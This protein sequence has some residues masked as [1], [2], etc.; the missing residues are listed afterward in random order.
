MIFG[1][2]VV[3]KL[4]ENLKPFGNKVLLVYGGGSIKKSG[5][6]D[7]VKELLKDFEVYELGGVAPNPKYT[8]VLE[9][10]KI[11]KEK[12]IEVI[13]PVGG[14]SVVDC[15]K[16][17]GVGAVYDGEAW[18]L[19]SMKV[20]TKATLPVVDVI[21]MA[22]T[23]SEY[24]FSAVITNEATGEKISYMSPVIYPKV[25]F[26]DPQ[27]TFTVPTK[28]TVAGVADAMNH[29]LEQYFSADTSILTDGMCIAALRSL[30]ENVKIVLEKPDDYQARA[31]IFVDATLGC[32]LIFAIGNALTGWPMHALEHALSAF[33]DITHGEGLAILTPHWMK[34]ILDDRTCE[35]FVKLGTDLF[36]MD[37]SM[38]KMEMANKVIDEFASFFK[39]LGLPM[40]LKEVGI[41]DKR[42][43]E[44]AKYVAEHDGLHQAYVYYP[45]K[46]EDIKAIFTACL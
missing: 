13:V 30:M 22:A 18:D 15:G 17:I 8:S 42:I 19:I 20:P 14:G 1:K 40:T 9:G 28:Q 45:L 6:Y 5:L 12:G 46:E 26:I 29:V 11:C 33:Y 7:K 10:I 35:R 44:M 2:N 43:G 41:D 24:D 36:K 32:N 37:P 25:S 39:S 16:A 27:Y 21:T 34:Y 3:N 38:D 31:E 4:P 23:G